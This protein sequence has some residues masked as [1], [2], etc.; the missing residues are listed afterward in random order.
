MPKSK[1][2]K[3]AEVLS[4]CSTVSLRCKLFVVKIS[5]MMV[6][7]VD[8]DLSNPAVATFDKADTLEAG[9]SGLL[10]AV[11]LVLLVIALSKVAAAIIQ[12]VT[13]PVVRHRITGKQHVHLHGPALDFCDG[14]ELPWLCLHREPFVPDEKR[15]VR[16]V[17]DGALSLRELNFSHTGGW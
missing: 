17:D 7:F 8:L 16:I 10:P 4:S 2:R 6:A 12:T 1:T 9:T 5:E 11:G 14:V 15:Q 3:S 13:G